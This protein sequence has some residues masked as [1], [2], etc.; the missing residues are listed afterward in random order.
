MIEHP[1]AG[2]KIRHRHRRDYAG[3]MAMAQGYGVG[4]GAYLSSIVASRPSLLVDMLR[5]GPRAVS[6][7]LRADSAKNRTKGTAYPRALTRTERLG[8]VRGPLAYLASRR[9]P[10]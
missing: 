7:V 6:Y 5:K 4:L 1:A 2:G 3:L 9:R 10:A 8:M